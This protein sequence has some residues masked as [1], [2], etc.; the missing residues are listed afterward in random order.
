[1]DQLRARLF[2][3]PRH[4]FTK[5]AVEAD[6]NL[7]AFVERQTLY[8]C[9]VRGTLQSQLDLFQQRIELFVLLTQ[10]GMNAR[11]HLTRVELLILVTGQALRGLQQTV[12]ERWRNHD[13]R[14]DRQRRAHLLRSVL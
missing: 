4:E 14:A 2:I 3:R 11:L 12:R 10:S 13:L 8:E 7:V 9:T 6:K 5:A 1:M